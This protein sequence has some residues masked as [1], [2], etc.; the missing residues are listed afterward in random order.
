[1]RGQL[2][3]VQCEPMQVLIAAQL[4][5]TC[6]ATCVVAALSA[7]CFAVRR[8]QVRL[9]GCGVRMCGSWDAALAGAAHGV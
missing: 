5:S 2:G 8:T 6:Q 1:M 3:F 9:M 4:S 7:A